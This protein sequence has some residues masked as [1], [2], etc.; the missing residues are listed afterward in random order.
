[1]DEVIKQ[2]AHAEA[3]AIG[4]GI[5]RVELRR[6]AIDR[7]FSH[8]AKYGATTDK[9]GIGLCDSTA[10]D[11]Y[12]AKTLGARLFVRHACRPLVQASGATT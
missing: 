12:A 9:E 7:I 3:H 6:G 8:Q 5:P 10:L 4:T 11:S 1:M 2:R